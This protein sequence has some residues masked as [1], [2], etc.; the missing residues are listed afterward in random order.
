MSMLIVFLLIVPLGYS[1]FSQHNKMTSLIFPTGFL[2]NVHD[3]WAS[4]VQAGVL[5]INYYRD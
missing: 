3:N 2:R 4:T 1:S 5:R